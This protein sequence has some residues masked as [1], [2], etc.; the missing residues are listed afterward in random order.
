MLVEEHTRRNITARTAEFPPLFISALHWHENCEICMLLNNSAT[1]LID[2]ETVNAVPGD[3]LVI[4][5][6]VP[7]QI[8]MTDK[9]TDIIIVHMRLSCFIEQ[10]IRLERIKPYISKKEIDEIPSLSEKINFILQTLRSEDAIIKEPKEN[11]FLYSTAA[12]LYYLLMR[13]FSVSGHS[14]PKNAERVEFYNITEYIN[15]NFKDDITVNSISSALFI[16]KRKLSEIFRKFAGMSINSYITTLRLKNANYL[17]MHGS[18]ISEAAYESGFQN[19]RTFNNAYKMQMGISPTEYIKNN[20][21]GESE[22]E[23]L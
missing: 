7:H 10:G 15:A 17:L 23:T 21:R 18:G 13:H 5:E 19:L 1:F 20:C 3:V 12:S 6:F 9:K 14:S 2:G 8:T 16:S 22:D 4:D 11:P